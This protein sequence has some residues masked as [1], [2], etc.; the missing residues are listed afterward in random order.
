M[1]AKDQLK[2]S[3]FYRIIDKSKMEVRNK[4]AYSKF[5]TRFNFPIDQQMSF[6]DIQA[7]HFVEALPNYLKFSFVNELFVLENFEYLERLQ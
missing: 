2:I 3:I 1:S 4:C 5:N 7:K 6:R